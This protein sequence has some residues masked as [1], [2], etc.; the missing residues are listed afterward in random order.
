[1]TNQ[2]QPACFVCIPMFLQIN[3]LNL[4]QLSSRR[5]MRNDAMAGQRPD[6]RI[7]DQSVVITIIITKNP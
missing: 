7:F 2:E 5:A 3:I 1:M 6:L 4:L